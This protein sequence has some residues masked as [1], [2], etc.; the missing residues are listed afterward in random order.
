MLEVARL[1]LDETAGNLRR[2]RID[3]EYA[4]EIAPWLLEQ[5]K[6]D[7]SAGARPLRRLVQ[8]WI[9]DAV[10][11]WLILHQPEERKVLQVSIADDG[12]PAVE[13]VEQ[14]ADLEERS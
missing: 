10:A 12:R 5:C 11:D 9:E 3:V 14:V 8:V 2:R 6:L 4:P 13:V 7:P 1:L